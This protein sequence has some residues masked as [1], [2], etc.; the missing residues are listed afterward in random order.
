MNEVAPCNVLDHVVAMFNGLLNM[1]QVV[2]VAWLTKRAITR[3]AVQRDRN[4]GSSQ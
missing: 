3:D 1:V 2:L 4:G